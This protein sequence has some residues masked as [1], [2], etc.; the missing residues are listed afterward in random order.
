MTPVD[1]SAV[2]YILPIVSFLLVAIVS[3][4]VISSS[5]IVEE[6]WLQIFLSLFIAVLFVSFGSAREYVEDVVPWFV[7]LLISAFLVFLLT[8]FIGKDVDFMKKGIG[9][10]FVVLLF[11]VFIVSGIV[12][13]SGSI[14]PYLPGNLGYEG[15][16]P[17]VLNFFDWLYSP[18]VGGAVLLI[19]VSALLAWVLARK[20]K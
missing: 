3:F 7:I 20:E 19:I 8:G 13:F 17:E 2:G 14:T 5:K 18:R 1:L 15:G 12:V 16:N 4:V 10:I 9:V 11:I 6:K